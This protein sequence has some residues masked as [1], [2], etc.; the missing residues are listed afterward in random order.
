ML[1]FD[2]YHLKVNSFTHYKIINDHKTRS[3][4]LKDK[5]EEDAND[6]STK[7]FS[8]TQSFILV[9]RLLRRFLPFEVFD[10]VYFYLDS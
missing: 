2:I 9:L 8:K 7:I 10:T 4:S 5:E 3:S 6:D 1:H